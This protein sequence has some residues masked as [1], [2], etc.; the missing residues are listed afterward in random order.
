MKRQIIILLMLFSL[1]KLSFGQ[2]IE[3]LF[4]V[5]PSEYTPQL[6]ATGKDSLLKFT[7]YTIPGGDSL[8]NEEIHLTK[9][10]DDFIQLNYEYTTGQN[11]FIQI[12]LRKFKK[13]SGGAVLVYAK[14][15]G[16]KMAFDQHSLLTFGYSKGRLY[17]NNNLGLP[18]TIP[19]SAFL[20]TNLPD[21]AKSQTL[22]TGYDLN[23]DKPNSIDYFIHPETDE[24]VE[25]IKRE[26]IIYTWDGNRFEKMTE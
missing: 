10:R 14:F 21:N 26:R 2:T 11:G 5:L 7:T 17:I 4:K 16:M 12:E 1:I 22:S 23:S 15:G 6:S 8:D 19:Q 9:N 24:E 3:E 20:N 25:W 18:E 13:K